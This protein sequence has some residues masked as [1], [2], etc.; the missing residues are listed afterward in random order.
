M[1]LDCHELESVISIMIIMCVCCLPLAV[2]ELHGMQ[3]LDNFASDLQLI[4]N[5]VT[6][7]AGM[8]LIAKGL[9]QAKPTAF[10]AYSLISSVLSEPIPSPTRDAIVKL[11]ADLQGVR[12]LSNL[13]CP[14]FEDRQ[15]YHCASGRF[16]LLTCINMWQFSILTPA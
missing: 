13:F 16:T 11:L 14:T 12:R 4:L 5:L 3:D 6:F 10:S 8:A 9:V 2:A 15:G 7:A 1:Y